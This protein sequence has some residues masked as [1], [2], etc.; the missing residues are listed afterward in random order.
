M[1]YCKN[2]KSC[3]VDL[4]NVVKV[5][6]RNRIN[7]WCIEFY[8]RNFE[9]P[10]FIFEYVD[11]KSRDKEFDVV[12]D[13]LHKISVNRSRQRPISSISENELFAVINNLKDR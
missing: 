5:I 8:E 11:E 4:S 7:V 12:Y 2:D 10:Q 1:F 13:T 3:A 9:A 6:K